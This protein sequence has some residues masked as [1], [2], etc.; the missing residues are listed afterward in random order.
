MIAA[1]VMATAVALAAGEATAQ[2]PAAPASHKIGFV[3]TE[4]VMREARVSQQAQ[5]EL[6]A[7]FKK[8]DQEIAG[9]PQGDIER[10]RNALLEDMSQRREEA[11][12]QIVD[13]ANAMIRRIAEEENFDA[14][15][16]EAAYAAPRIDLTAKVIKALD[17]AR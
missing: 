9:G 15:F 11:L 4:R 2:Q 16:L 3:S 1:G 7:E 17:A 12:K 14:V 5:K 13:K 6:E 8:R 10:R